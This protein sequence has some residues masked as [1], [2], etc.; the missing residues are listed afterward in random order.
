MGMIMRIA[1]CPHAAFTC[2][3]ALALTTACGGR[4]AAKD[5]DPSAEASAESEGS[6]EAEAAPAPAADPSAATN[7]PLTAADI[8]VWQKGMAGELEAVRAAAAKMKS[9]KTENDTLSA[10]MEVQE[11][12][13]Q[14]AGAKAAGV[15]LERYKVIH[16]NLSAAASYMTRTLAASTRPCSPPRSAPSCGSRTRPS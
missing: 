11:N 8:D 16:S 2:L 10:M 12:A 3:L 9:A 1:R 6:A 15:D 13:T 4:D 5:A 14:A 7:A